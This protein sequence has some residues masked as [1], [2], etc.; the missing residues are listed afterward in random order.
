MTLKSS[1]G[2]LSFESIPKIM[3]D[4]KKSSNMLKNLVTLAEEDLIEVSNEDSSRDSL[5]DTPI[6]SVSSPSKSV[7]SPSS[8]PNSEKFRKKLKKEKD[9]KEKDKKLMREKNKVMIQNK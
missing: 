1:T 7:S 3:I 4:K 9:K 5:S 2:T 6:P 8:E